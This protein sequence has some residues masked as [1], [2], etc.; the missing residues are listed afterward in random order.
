MKREYFNTI[1]FVFFTYIY[2]SGS[3]VFAQY[4]SWTL[5]QCI[6]SA[7]KNNLIIKQTANQV[8]LNEINLIQSKNNKLPVIDGAAGQSI[9]STNSSGNSSVNVN[10][11][12]TIFK[13]FQN[14]YTIRQNQTEVQAAGYDLDA[15][16][17]DLI[18]S[19][20]DAYLQT[21][22]AEELEKNDSDQVATTQAQYESALQYVIAGK[23][24]DS[25]L[26]Q[27]QAE[28]AG[29]KLSLINAKGQLK[30]AK[31]NLQQLI[32]I[33]FSPD[34]EIETPLLVDLPDENATNATGIYEQAL[35]T[36]P[37]IKASQQKIQSAE[38]G[39]KISKS[40]ALPRLSLSGNVGTNYFGSARV[41]ETTYF[42]ETENIGYLQSDPTELVFA[43][44][45]TP[46][47]T[48]KKYSF[49]KQFS[50]NFSQSLS[51]SLSVPIFNNNQVK[52]NSRK[53]KIYLENAI[54]DNQIAENKL[55]KKIEQACI[56]VEN[57][58]TKY[59]AGKVYIDAAKASYVNEKSKYEN[60]M[61]SMSDLIQESNAYRKSISEFIQTKYQLLYSLKILDYYKGIP[62]NK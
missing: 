20:I 44:V 60:G 30:T 42:S 62:I 34:F 16:K 49:R 19:I 29:N 39:L 33:P 17:N 27:I 10:G 5:N 22:Y 54:I 7:M 1:V 4:T 25:D 18:L 23:K 15:Q 41:T 61:I 31:L 51:L 3:S 50:D 35:K 57:A 14:K 11:S 28:L 45:S 2:L 38:Y 13:G 24:T 46:V 48:D 56:D 37:E 32:N 6:D 26:L 12:V 9:N 8:Q 53:Q 58:L 36:F 59:N 52:N 55:V 43:N 47:Y 21:L 40:E